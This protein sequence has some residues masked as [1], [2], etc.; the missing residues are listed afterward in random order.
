MA[1][2]D[3]QLQEETEYRQHEFQLLGIILQYPD[4]IDEVAD[5]L[6]PK[7]FQD[8]QAQ[9]IYKILL[10]QS[11]QDNQVSRTKL[12]MR[13]KQDRV[14]NNPEETIQNLTSGFNT[15]EEVNPTIDI[16]KKNYQKNLLVRA[17]HKIEKLASTPGLDIDD[18]QAQ[19]QELI[20]EATNESTDL[21]KHIYSMEEALMNSFESYLDRKHNRAD[22]G[23]R[24]GF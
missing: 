24:S 14:I 21:E 18:Y 23:L 20:F 8:S 13:L 11:Q 9:V 2:N 17:A 6:K 22:V 4:T 19:A 12:L 5:V 15:R 7:H 3:P 16:I 1:V 10:E